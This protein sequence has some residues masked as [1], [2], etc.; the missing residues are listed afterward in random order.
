[1]KYFDSPVS[2][3]HPLRLRKQDIK[4]T[5]KSVITENGLNEENYFVIKYE[6]GISYGEAKFDNSPE[7][8]EL[9]KKFIKLLER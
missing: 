8:I 4:N 7:G 2:V 9:M 6:S 3:G 1:M 5:K